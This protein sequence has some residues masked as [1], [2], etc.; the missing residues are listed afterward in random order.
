MNGAMMSLITHRLNAEGQAQFSG[1]V[2]RL[3]TTLQQQP[4]FVSLRA[5]ADAGEPA[6][7]HVLLEMADEAALYAWTSGSDKTPLLREIE[8][9]ATQPWTA[10]RLRE[11]ALRL[12]ETAGAR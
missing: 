5:F 7:H 10:L 9:L 1:W 2:S 12:E 6:A 11:L 8:S 4:G 3:R